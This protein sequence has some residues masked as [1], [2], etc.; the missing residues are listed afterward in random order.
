MPGSSEKQRTA[1][2]S[3]TF[4]KGDPSKTTDN[5]DNETIEPRKQPWKDAWKDANAQ[6]DGSKGER[7]KVT[8]DEKKNV[9]HLKPHLAA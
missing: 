6:Y 2:S 7:V 5:R 3:K 8:G 1:D 4:G 9:V